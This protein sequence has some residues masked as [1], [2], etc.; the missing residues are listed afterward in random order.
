MTGQIRRELH[1]NLL[2]TRPV[3]VA[4]VLRHVFCLSSK[5]VHQR[6]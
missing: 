2:L 3:Y 1:S 5:S 4:L 6:H